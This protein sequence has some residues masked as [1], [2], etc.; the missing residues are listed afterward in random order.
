M[1]YLVANPEDWFSHDVV[2]ILKHPKDADEMANSV[3]LDQVWLLIQELS[4]LGLYCLPRP[5]CMNS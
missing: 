2:Y 1:S 4:D 5:V 3:D